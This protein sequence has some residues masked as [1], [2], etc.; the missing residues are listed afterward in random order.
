MLDADS[1]NR[2]TNDKMRLQIARLITNLRKKVIRENP[3]ATNLS[4]PKDLTKEET[5]FIFK[6]QQKLQLE[7]VNELQNS[8]KDPTIQQ[9]L[10]YKLWDKVHLKFQIEL[11]DF[12]IAFDKHDM[13]NDYDVQ[14]MTAYAEE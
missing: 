3:K 11:E 7:A 8:E 2:E 6:Y 4:V 9:I 5:L 13:A 1:P 14:E 10:T 12:E